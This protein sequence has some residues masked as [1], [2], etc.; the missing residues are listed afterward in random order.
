MHIL[1]V[2]STEKMQT[3]KVAYCSVQLNIVTLQVLGYC[4]TYTV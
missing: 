3:S 4:C 2:K 1:A